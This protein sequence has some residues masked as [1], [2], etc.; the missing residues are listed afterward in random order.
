MNIHVR[1]P[2]WTHAMSLGMELL[3]DTVSIGLLLLE[4]AK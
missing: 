1:V 2:L 4:T 3:D